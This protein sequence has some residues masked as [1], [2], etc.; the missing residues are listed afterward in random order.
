MKTPRYTDLERFPAGGYV[1]AS[2]TNIR[3]TFARAR[4]QFRQFG[5]NP[6]DPATW[7]EPHQSNFKRS[8]PLK[9]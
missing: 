1:P 3:R 7:A 5:E 2:R 6:L 9:D 4:S 8:K